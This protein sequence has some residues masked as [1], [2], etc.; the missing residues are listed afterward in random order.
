MLKYVKLIPGQI[1]SKVHILLPTLFV[2]IVQSASFSINRFTAL[3]SNNTIE[4]PL[5]RNFLSYSK[6]L[7]Y[8]LLLIQFNYKPFFILMIQTNHDWVDG[9][10]V[11]GG[12]LLHNTEDCY[13]MVN[14]LLNTAHILIKL[15]CSI[16]EL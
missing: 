6:L 3:T 4:Y 11:N 1:I 15:F 16:S 7:S 8:L 9:H 14:S 13:S 12:I 10:S 2:L 5:P